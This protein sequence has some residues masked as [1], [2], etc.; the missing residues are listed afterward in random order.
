LPSVSDEDSTQFGRMLRA[1]VGREPPRIR[2]GNRA[3]LE[4]VEQ[5]AWPN[6]GDWLTFPR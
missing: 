1:R 2:P 4:E 6:S 5:I 3:Q